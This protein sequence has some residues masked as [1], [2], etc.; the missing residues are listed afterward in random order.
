MPI[1]S[2]AS[3]LVMRYLLSS[4]AFK[5]EPEIFIALI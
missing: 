2:A 3:F 5:Y 1:I 4:S